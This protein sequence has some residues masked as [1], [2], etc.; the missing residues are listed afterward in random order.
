MAG[1]QP[2]VARERRPAA[3]AAAGAR[4]RTCRKYAG[5]STA[6]EPS[7]ARRSRRSR[8]ARVTRMRSPSTGSEV[9]TTR[10]PRRIVSRGGVEVVLVDGRGQVEH[11]LARPAR[12]RT[13]RSCRRQESRTPRTSGRRIRSSV[14]VSSLTY[15][16]YDCTSRDPDLRGCALD[17]S[18]VAAPVDVGLEDGDGAHPEREARLVGRLGLGRVAGVARCRAPP[19]RPRSRPRPRRRARCGCGV[20]QRRG[21]RSAPR[22]AVAGP[23]CASV[24]T[25]TGT[26]RIMPSTATTAEPAISH[27][28]VARAG[29]ADHG[30]G[31]AEPDQEQAE[32][33]RAQAGL[34]VAATPGQHGHHVL[35]RGDP[36]RHDRGQEGAQQPE[37]RA[38][39][40]RCSGLTSNG[41]SQE[42]EKCWTTGSSAQ[43]TTTPRTTPSTAAAPPEDQTAGEDHAA[44]LLR[45]T[46]ARRHQ[47]QGPRLTA[48]ADGERRPGEQHHLEQCHH[49]DQHDDRDPRLV[50][51]GLP[52]PDLGGQ[53][54]VG[55]RV[56]DHRAREH[57]ARRPG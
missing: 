16:S 51:L 11:L 27:A 24:A 45:R 26:S 9:K 49:H 48:G 4:P 55:W 25:T 20:A 23:A 47:G 57:E 12:C 6:A 39:S 52:L 46:S 19:R 18:G 43:P 42:S 8:P 33:R 14:K 31:D 3:T 38:T 17:Q 1:L 15:G 37:R 56:L 29:G 35:P 36:R 2:E 5:S 54:G 32:Q 34:A 21:R 44:R 13:T 10:P 53:R 50:D 30:A 28:A 22:A 7:A 40:A 41:P